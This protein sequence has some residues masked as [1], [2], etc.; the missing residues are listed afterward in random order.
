MFTPGRIKGNYQF[1]YIL[2]NSHFYQ[3]PKFSPLL[4][5]DKYKLSNMI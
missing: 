5:Y 4:R 2:F 1:I 3:F